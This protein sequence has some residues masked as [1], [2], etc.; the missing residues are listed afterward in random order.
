MIPGARLVVLDSGHV[1][2]T[3]EPDAIRRRAA[4]HFADAVSPA[5]CARA[6]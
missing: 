3:S 5:P 4:A 2:H 1:P 6:A